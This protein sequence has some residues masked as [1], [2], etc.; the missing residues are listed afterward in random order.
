MHQR[1]ALDHDIEQSDLE[2]VDQIFGIVE[3]DRLGGP[4]FAAFGGLKRI[5]ESVE[6]IGLGGRAVILDQ[7]RLDPRIVDLADRGLGQRVVGI[8]TDEDSVIAVAPA[9]HSRAKHVGNHCRFV[10]RRNEHC[11]TSGLGRGRQRVGEGAR[12][13]AVDRDR[14]PRASPEI[15]QVDRKI[16]DREQQKSG[17][18]E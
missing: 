4:M 2:R 1:R 12:I 3:H 6:A 8:V 15:N 11:D 10:P 7:H 14:T 13:A 5:I 18:G 17:G 9:L 16:V